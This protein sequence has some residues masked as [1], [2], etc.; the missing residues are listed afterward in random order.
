VAG[1][2]T[3]TVN[4]VANTRSFGQGMMS[5]WKSAGTFKGKMGA[6]ATQ[7]RGVLGPAL[8]AAAAAAGALAIKLGKEG[9][10][11]A[12]KDAKTVAVLGETLKNLG[13]AH[14]QTGIEDFI[15]KMES[16]RGVADEE[17][18]PAFGLLMMATED[19]GQSMELMNAALDASIAT[20]K[21]FKTVYEAMARAIQTQTAGRLSQYNI[22]VD[23]A[24]VK[25]E[26]MAAAILD[27]TG[28]MKGV[29]AAEARTLEGRL[30]ILNVEYDNVKEAFGRGLLAGFGDDTK[31]GV[32]SLTE[33]LRN[34]QPVAETAGQQIGSLVRGVGD[35]VGALGDVGSSGGGDNWL[36]SFSQFWQN[37][38][39]M[40][41]GRVL[42]GIASL[43]SGTDDAIT[44]VDKMKDA[45]M[46]ARGPMQDLGDA[47]GEAGDE[48]GDAALEFATLNGFLSDTRALLNYEEAL[49]R[50]R[51]GLKE[52]GKTF[53]ENTEKGRANYENLLNFAEMTAV[54]AETQ[55]TLSDKA[56][57][58][59]GALDSLG[60]MMERT[61]MSPEQR[62]KLLEP[63]QALIDDLAAAGVNVDAVQAKL[64]ALKDK[65]VTVTVY[66]QHK[67][68]GRED[69]YGGYS[70]GGLITGPGGPRDDMVPA[71]LSNGEFVV[72]A[73]AVKKFGVQFLSM[74]NAGRM[75]ASLMSEA[76]GPS[77]P[78]PARSG[79]GLTI[80]GG[81]TV[82]QVGGEPAERSLPRALRRMAWQAG[83]DG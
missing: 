28:K 7:L 73:A 22:V 54:A 49:D 38:G 46:E 29:A 21:D 25:T 47:V 34:L 43:V 41:T 13:Q 74:L 9:V 52:N 71:R 51:V 45:A 65:T 81:I 50:L 69:A 58:A 64:D 37:T 32:D 2:R 30:R 15:A 18:R 76:P 66:T 1:G 59:Q 11:A 27:A 19:V 44:G 17:L 77:R 60:Q 63:F 3:L 80:N 55:G 70:T 72:Q 68:D 33:A 57:F 83:L 40:A 24:T 39:G 42:S 82:T 8:I 78:M 16:A 67:S 53:D 12:I 23:E 6:V 26:G 4:L 48:A 36:V 14:E 75:P 20:G 5:A 31:E 61:N 10:D 35:L 62:A 56:A 79:G